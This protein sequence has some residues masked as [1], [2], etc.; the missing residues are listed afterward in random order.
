MDLPQRKSRPVTGRAGNCGSGVTVPACCFRS[1]DVD[2]PRP[3]R[4]PYLVLDLVEGQ[5]IVLL[6]RQ[7]VPAFDRVPPFFRD[8]RRDNRPARP[9]RKNVRHGHLQL[10]G[11]HLSHGDNDF[12]RLTC[13]QAHRGR[14]S[15]LFV[16]FWADAT[17]PAS[18]SR[19]KKCRPSTAEALRWGRTHASLPQ[20]AVSDRHHPKY[21]LKAWLKGRRVRLPDAAPPAPLAGQQHHADA[22]HF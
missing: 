7:F 21:V 6:D 14:I 12:A 15:R 1:N 3:L 19:M 17:F 22:A 4:G 20:R 13:E 11:V 16:S 10:L 9:V 5:V 2:E 18:S 8:S